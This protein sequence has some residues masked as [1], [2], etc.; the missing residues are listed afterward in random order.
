MVATGAYLID[1]VLRFRYFTEYKFYLDT[2]EKKVK[3][4]IQKKPKEA[5]SVGL[6]GSRNLNL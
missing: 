5:D 4:L 3:I 2:K 6:V 1:K